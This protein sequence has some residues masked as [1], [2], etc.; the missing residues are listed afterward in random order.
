MHTHHL[1][2]KRFFVLYDVC[3]ENIFLS[4]LQLKALHSIDSECEILM[5]PLSLND[6]KRKAIAAIAIATLR[7]RKYDFKGQ[8]TLSAEKAIGKR[9]ISAPKE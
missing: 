1:N 5:H 6:S 3:P 7:A 8:G 4:T 2:R 9:S